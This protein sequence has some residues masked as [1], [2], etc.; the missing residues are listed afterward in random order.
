MH[1]M[2]SVYHSDSKT[3]ETSETC[4]LQTMMLKVKPKAATLKQC[5]MILLLPTVP[6]STS[7]LLTGEFLMC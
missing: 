5:L 3:G 4:N 7:V 2:F 6:P 1:A